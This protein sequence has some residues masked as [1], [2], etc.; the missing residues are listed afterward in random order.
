ME[1]GETRPAIKF[2]DM[3]FQS[4]TYNNFKSLSKYPTSLLG[5]TS[6]TAIDVPLE[7]VIH[8]RSVWTAWFQFWRKQHHLRIN[9]L[10]FRSILNEQRIQWVQLDK[11]KKAWKC[12][13]TYLHLHRISCATDKAAWRTPKIRMQRFAFECGFFFLNSTNIRNS[14]FFLTALVWTLYYIMMSAEKKYAPHT[15]CKRMWTWRYVCVCVC[16]CARAASVLDRTVSS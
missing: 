9:V 3:F 1:W 13:D 14:K 16:V 8:L 4:W 6:A 7:N 11:L 15:H 10:F 5:D 12:N 2:W